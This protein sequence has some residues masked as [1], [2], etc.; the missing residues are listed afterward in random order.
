MHNITEKNSIFQS[1]LHFRS[2]SNLL[3]RCRGEPPIHVNAV[4]QEYERESTVT[5]STVEQ[6]VE[7]NATATIL[8]ARNQPAKE[9]PHRATL[10]R[11][12]VP[13]INLRATCQ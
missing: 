13:M 11:E 5:I 12:S 3:A 2:E 9:V 10:R 8:N 1:S 4:N 7:G 6:S